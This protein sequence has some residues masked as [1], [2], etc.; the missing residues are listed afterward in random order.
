MSNRGIIIKRVFI[1]DEQTLKSGRESFDDS[2]ARNGRQNLK[3]GKQKL[4]E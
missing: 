4:N 2:N 1:Q 3:R